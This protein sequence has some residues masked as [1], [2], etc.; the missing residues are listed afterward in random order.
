VPQIRFNF[1]NLFLI[2]LMA[3]LLSGAQ[4]TFWFQIFGSLPAPLLWLNLVLYLIL[5]RKPFEGML[6]IYLMALFLRP[7]TAMPLGVLW[8]TLLIVSLLVGFAK[9]RVFWPGTRYFVMASFGISICY[10]VTYFIIS[11]W[12]ETNPAT[13]SFFHRFFEI[14]FTGLTAIPLYIIFAWIDNVTHKETLPE[15]GGLDA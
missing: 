6:T 2:L 5:Y 3:L 7:F 4:T 11:R 15:S 9:K 10:H 14:V 12:F 13:F 8:L 1:L